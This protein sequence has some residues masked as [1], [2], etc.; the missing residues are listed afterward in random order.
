MA[1]NKIDGVIEAV[2]YD[3]DGKI[4]VVRTYVRH[5]VVWSDH[6]IIDR[7]DLV[8]RLSNGKHFVIGG[9]KQNL[10]NVFE[11]GSKVRLLNGHVITDGQPAAR[12]MLAGLSVF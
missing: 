7:T 5:G 9:R 12:D 3:P 10:G 1:S 2:R 6:I 11:T 4:R 8:E